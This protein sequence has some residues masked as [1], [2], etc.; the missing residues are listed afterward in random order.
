MW[1]VVVNIAGTV[2]PR[3]SGGFSDGYMYL[4]LLSFNLCYDHIYPKPCMHCQPP[5][6]LTFFTCSLLCFTQ[7]HMNVNARSLLLGLSSG[8][9]S[10]RAVTNSW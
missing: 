7:C 6:L 4:S 1:Q 10:Q 3:V 5:S 8:H 9:I 2:Y